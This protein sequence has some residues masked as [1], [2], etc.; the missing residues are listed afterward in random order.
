MFSVDLFGCCNLAGA[1]AGAHL[2]ICYK[3][4]HAWAASIAISNCSDFTVLLAACQLCHYSLRYQCVLPVG[5]GSQDYDAGVYVC[6]WVKRGPTGIIGTNQI[7]AE[8]TVASIL[9]D[10]D[11]LLKASSWK[12]GLAGLEA[13]LQAHSVPYVTYPEWEKLNAYEV[14]QGEQVGK[15]REKIANVGEMLS[16]AKQK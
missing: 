16:V 10:R 5:V 15:P 1:C 3:V 12:E 7:D 8:E 13:Q 11:E 2:L 14:Q 4:T 9:Q 6:G